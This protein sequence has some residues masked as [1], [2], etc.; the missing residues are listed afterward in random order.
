MYYVCIKCIVI[1]IRYVI[2]WGGFKVFYFITNNYYFA[3]II[4]VYIIIQ[5]TTMM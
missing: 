4:H 2:S 3:D 5:I 1:C